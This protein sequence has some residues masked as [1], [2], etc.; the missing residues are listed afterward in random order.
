[1][2]DGCL[3]RGRACIEK[4][5]MGRFWGTATVAGDWTILCMYVMFCVNTQYI[6]KYRALFLIRLGIFLCKILQA[7]QY[8]YLDKHASSPCSCSMYAISRELD[9]VHAARYYVEQNV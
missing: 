1:M 2:G 4:E 8:G 5:G 7:F 3:R 6:R 9:K